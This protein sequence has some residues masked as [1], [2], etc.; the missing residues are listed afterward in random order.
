MSKAAKQLCVSNPV[1][2]KAVADLEHA[3]GVRLLDRTP[4]G[5][6][7]TIYGRALLDRGLVA[8]DEL[9]QAVKQIE[10]LANPAAGELRIGSPIAIA[11]G[12]VSAV[13]ERLSVQYPQVVFQLF[14]L[15]AD[16]A[17]HLLDERKVDLVVNRVFGPNVSDSMHVEVLYD[18]PFVVAAGA[19]TPWARRRRLTLD[20]LVNER[21]T[22][23]PPDTLFGA[24]VTEAFNASG[25]TVPKT[26]VV[27]PAIP[28]R[29]ALLATGGFLTII[30]RSA[31]TFPAKNPNVAI[32]PVKLP[33][34]SIPIGAITLKNRT[35][36]PLVQLF[37]NCAR[38]VV[39]G[40]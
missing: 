6:E 23:P 17:N 2:T 26:V 16:S 21:W 12:F 15:G 14:A 31:L 7:V 22:L 13:I 9:R 29:Q 38:E 5:V 33:L 10:L 40:L 11:A 37:I 25:L 24:A 39:R 19:Q 28:V 4:R 1:V 20:E 35:P 27:T 32:L 18:E 3:M 30:P 36:N 34:R 8:F